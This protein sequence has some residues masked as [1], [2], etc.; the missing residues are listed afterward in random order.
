MM[1]E[2]K[3][4]W[5]TIPPGTPDDLAG[6][7]GQLLRG[8]DGPPAR[9]RVSGGG[10]AI[11]TGPRLL[12]A[13]GIAAAAVAAPLVIG[14]GDPAYAVAKNPDGT[15]TVTLTELRDPEG[16]ETKLSAIGVTSDVTFLEPGKKCA[17]HRITSADL[18][19]GS[20]NPTE[21]NKEELKEFNDQE[22]WRSTK[23]TRPVSAQTFQIS[24][25]H[26]ERGETLVLEF[27]DNQNPRQPWELGAWLAKADTPVK[28]CVAVDDTEPLQENAPPEDT[29]PTLRRSDPPPVNTWG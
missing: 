20:K 13:A 15:I 1:D 24:P 27:R 6:A 17:D 8:M 4:M 28:S 2:L 29:T 25:Q 3:S 23:V 5:A 18:A 14:D 10:Q 9:R 21:M 11:F 26:M 7:R 12:V 16:L 22:N 19:Y